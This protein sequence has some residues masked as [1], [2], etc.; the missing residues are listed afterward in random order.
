M[1]Q[2]VVSNPNM[3]E[4]PR[5]ET[6]ISYLR[7]IFPESE[8][9]GMIDA[10]AAGA[11]TYVK[12]SVSSQS[13][14][15]W[16]F[17]DTHRGKLVIEFKADART[18]FA[19]ETA[20][21]EL[22][23]YIAGLW[24]ENGFDSSFC[25]V[26]TDVLWWEVLR[27]VPTTTPSDGIYNADM[28]NLEQVE[29]LDATEPDEENAHHLYLLL[30]RILINEYLLP[31]TAENLRRDFGLT[32]GQYALFSTKIQDIITDAI[33]TPEVELAVELWRHHQQYNSR[34]TSTFDIEFYANQ[35]YM[36]VL[37]RL[38][39]AACFQDKM[40][41]TIDDA[42]IRAFING[43]FFVQQKRL[44]NFVEEDFWGWITTPPWIDSLLDFARL[45][46]HN[47]R[48]YD[49]RNAS[50]ENVLRLIYDE[51]MLVEQSDLLGQRS[52]PEALAFPVVDYLLRDT[53][54][55]TRFLDPACGSGNLIRI[56]LLK[57]RS[58][59]E[60]INGLSAQDQLGHLI[61]LV[62]GID[63]DPV[64]VI[65]S[66]A[67]WAL[68]LAD[69]ID[70]ANELVNLPIYHAD[71]LFVAT[72]QIVST[73]GCQK[74]SALPVIDFDNTQIE[75]PIELFNNTTAFDKFVKW[76][77]QRAKAMANKSQNSNG[78]L[79]QIDPTTIS[80]NLRNLF[81]D[82]YSQA[83]E[84]S[85]ETLVISMTKLA[86]EF[87]QRIIDRRNGIWA[88]VLRN[89]Y[90]PSLFAGYFDR[91]A[92]NPPWLTMSSLPDVLYKHQ[93]ELRA[94]SFRIKPTGSAFPH[95]E[96]AT[97]FALHSVLHFL[98]PDGCAA[99]ILPR[100]IFDGDNHHH[101]RLGEFTRIAPFSI[102]EMWDLKEVDDLFK[103]PSCVLFGTQS[104]ENAH[105]SDLPIPAR[106]WNEL[107]SDPDKA[108]EGSIVLSSLGKKSAWQENKSV[109]QSI[110]PQN[111]YTNAF[112]EGADLMPRTS[113][114]VERVNDNPSQ[115]LVAVQTSKAEVTN[116]N[117]KKLKGKR[118][119]GLVNARYLFS[120]VTSNI[121][122]PFVILEDQLPTVLLP[123]EFQ[124]GVPTVLSNL[125]LID[126][127]DERTAEWFDTI[128]EEL[129][130]EK[131][132]KMI[133]ERIDE[134]GKL[135]QQRYTGYRFLVHTGAGGSIPC[136]AIQTIDAH[137]ERPFIA[138][139]T[140]YVYGTNDE[141]EAYYLIGLLNTQIIANA[142]KPYQAHGA[143]GA[144]HIHKLAVTMI[145]AYQPENEGHYSIV[146]CTKQI[147]VAA[148]SALTEKMCNQ[149][150]AVSSR[151]KALRR[152]I[153][154]EL[155]LLNNVVQNVLGE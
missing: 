16:G 58:Q 3:K 6:F 22:R 98:K 11:E 29:T 2:T 46:Y 150:S 152:A 14:S 84:E 39:V 142:I 24:T 97:T 149:V 63:I 36:V 49:F 40:S 137:A 121:L 32:S 124:N 153:S 41:T 44:A 61:N 17:I 60:G 30:R 33:Q 131:E 122:L 71:S 108:R 129:C 80:R 151:R 27:P 115:K 100:S 143:F 57:K 42:A 104:P 37:S 19:Q 72:D 28:V 154:E 91:I 106:F 155:I 55:F 47:L 68:T 10:L 38:I 130:N 25:C 94:E 95:T 4:T 45:L 140:T 105:N 83:L 117:N 123:I 96:I 50:Q 53:E 73:E 144:R 76:C 7:T 103:L 90:R 43:N 21:T 113:L 35:I 70:A 141:D 51:M 116:Q 107:D 134:R 87:A 5:K 86:M 15:E 81:G 136:A 147:T 78:H 146:E 89:S 66:K 62:V 64:A 135:S 114:F 120:T 48:A 126:R 119:S 13:S 1:L 110:T 111:H 59:L 99:F 77:S 79:A 31:I 127:G 26:I 128:D 34:Q 54:P 102:K 92:C 74:S 75:V 56:A 69:L 85:A 118:F 148:K 67:V 88:F 18:S 125:E 139:Q 132:K 138:D 109:G 20:D 8:Y 112:R 65:L 101:F 23:R 52:T 93:L 133:R 145:P 82:A 9:S 12:T